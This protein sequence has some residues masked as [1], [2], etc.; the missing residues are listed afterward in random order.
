[1]TT[2][3]SAY[4]AHQRAEALV[5]ATAGSGVSADGPVDAGKR[6]PARVGFGGVDRNLESIAA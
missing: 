5:C 3:L 1:M 4:P 6:I 2:E